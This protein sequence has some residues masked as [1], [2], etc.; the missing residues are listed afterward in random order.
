MTE[1]VYARLSPGSR[2]SWLKL[3]ADGWGF[4]GMVIEPMAAHHGQYSVLMVRAI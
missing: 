1:T 4:S 3:L 2:Y